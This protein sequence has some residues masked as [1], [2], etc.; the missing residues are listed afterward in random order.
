MSF[1]LP[2]LVTSAL[3]LAWQN[4]VVAAPPLQFEPYAFETN[5]HGTI[6]AE[7]A[8]LDVP[9]RHDQPDGARLQLRVVRLPASGGQSARAPIV[10]LAGGPGGSGVGTARGPRWPVFDRVRQHADV[11]LFDQR[12]TGLSGRIPEC[13]YRHAFAPGQAATPD[14]YLAALSAVA[15]RCVALW[16]SQGI[17]LDAYNTLDS[18]HDIEALRTALGVEQLSLWGMSY[19]THLAMA[20][21]REHGAHVDRAVL[22]GTEGPDDTLKLPLA[23]DALLVRLSAAI[24]QDPGAEA[25]DPDLAGTVRRLLATLEQT[26]GEG[27]ARLSGSG[28]ITI[29]RFDAELAI[30]AALGRSQTARL[31][32]MA[33]AAAEQ[34]NYDV[35]AEFVHAVRDALGTFNA[36]PL[37]TDIA[38]G[39][40]SERLAL[41]EHGER[42]S[43][44]GPALNFPLPGLAAGLGIR[45]LDAGFRTTLETAIP[46][47]FISG[48]LDG[49]TPPANAEAAAAGFSHARHLLIDGAGHDDELW[50][51]HAQVPARI[52]AF[53]AGE[54]TEDARLEAPPIAF[55]VSVHGELWRMLIRNADGSIRV[56]AIGAALIFGL[57]VAAGVWFWR[58]RLRRRRLAA[59]GS[60]QPTR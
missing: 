9:A 21:M 45:T 54:A 25:L 56:A 39:A 50:L 15:A 10:Y 6:A 43:L 19:G 44:L 53:F 24:R 13:P 27:R 14:T 30:A 5:A 34:G 4:P 18:A 38:S 11:L 36:M 57:I 49:R 16:R 7:I 52:A 40:S 51:G 2:R 42:E 17:D 12:G 48:S 32:P 23:A 46:T 60:V 55:A 37:A 47:L 58:S 3:L 35:L 33:I 59:A 22:M 1:S 8:W 31:L 20:M 28:V 41:I 26:P 29:G